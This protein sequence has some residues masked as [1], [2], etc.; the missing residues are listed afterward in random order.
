VRYFDHVLTLP[1]PQTSTEAAHEWALSPGEPPPPEIVDAIGSYLATAEVLGRR[2]GELHARIAEAEPDDGAFAPEPYTA[3]DV[4]ATAKA[5]RRD[6]EHQLAL[7]DTSLDRLDDRRRELARQVLAHSRELLHQI[8][9]VR[10]LRNA[11]QRIRCHGDY[12]LG[13]VL[14][15]EGDVVIIDFEG[16]PAR[17]LAE[18]RTKCSP[19]RD[20][21]GMLR[22]FSYAAL[23]GLHA[24]TQT[25][26]DD[27]ERLVPWADLWEAWVGASFLRAYLAAVRGTSFL[28]SQPDDLDALLKLFLV[29]KAQYELGY[30]LNS[31][32]DWVHVPLAGLLRLRT[33]LHA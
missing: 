17:P 22:S 30:E 25:R 5:I 14:V 7:L 20:V 23:T 15:T 12:H 32:P 19:L 2:T 28:P 26:P 33:P 11:G 4:E 18:R 16:E 6:A 27:V 10:Q 21:A 9:D 24:A 3:R 1:A 8:G 29:D 31:R 13:Q